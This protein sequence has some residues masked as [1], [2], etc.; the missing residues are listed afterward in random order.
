CLPRRKTIP[1]HGVVSKRHVSIGFP[2]R[3]VVVPPDKVMKAPKVLVLE[4]LGNLADEAIKNRMLVH[5]HVESA[6]AGII[7][8]FVVTG[9]NTKECELAL[10]Q[11]VVQHAAHEMIAVVQPKSDIVGICEGRRDSSL[12]SQG[13]FLVGVEEQDPRGFEGEGLEHPI[14]FLR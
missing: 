8:P 4:G 6:P 13:W 9:A 5:L 7:D 10:W 2:G 14:T 3:I 1:D 11:P 12:K